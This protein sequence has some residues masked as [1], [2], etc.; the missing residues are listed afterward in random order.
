MTDFVLVFTLHHLVHAIVLHLH[1]HLLLVLPLQVHH[2][3]R[4]LLR[5]LDLL[6]RPHLLL[7]QKSDPIRQQLRILFDAKTLLI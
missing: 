3:P 6:P 5:L 2:L 7:L 4:S 1:E